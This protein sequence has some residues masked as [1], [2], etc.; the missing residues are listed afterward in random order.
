[1]TNMT[2]TVRTGTVANV[3]ETAIPEWV[4]MRDTAVRLRKEVQRRQVDRPTI[5]DT[6]KSVSDALLA[7]DGPA[8]MQ[9]VLDA[10]RLEKH[11][12]DAGQQDLDAI[13]HAMGRAEHQLRTIEEDSTDAVVT[14]IRGR[15]DK[16]ASR[17]YGLRHRPLSAQEAIELGAID[18]W[19]VLQELAGEWQQLAA[20]YQTLTRHTVSGLDVSIL[21]AAA[22]CDDPLANHPYMIG[23]RR[24]AAKANVRPQARSF[25]EVQHAW[26]S[27]APST[28]FPTDQP[29]GGALPMG[30]DPVHWIT[31]LADKHALVVHDPH[32]GIALWKAAEAATDDL[33]AHSAESR[34]V[35]RVQYAKLV[36]DDQLETVADLRPL[37]EQGKRRPARGSFFG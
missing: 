6:S 28:Q 16:I 20:A 10:A 25:H 5:M 9:A 34:A 13:A 4:T 14:E 36:G 17:V 35:A 21:A 7:A 31:Y 30:A 19:K 27:N 33:T 29:R 2:R 32:E 11:R 15:V 1:M 3:L 26:A 22:F 23:R 8:D 37:I 24:A 12:L 18:E